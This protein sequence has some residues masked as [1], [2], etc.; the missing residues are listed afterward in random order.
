MDA[1]ASEA[2]QS[3]RRYVDWRDA[4]IAD[5][6]SALMSMAAREIQRVV[7]CGGSVARKAR[8][9]E[10]PDFRALLRRL[11]ALGA[12]CRRALGDERAGDAEAVA[13]YAVQQGPQLALG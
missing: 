1:P 2:E 8:L 7:G 4:V 3:L 10:V 13:R 11:P 6:R 5:C 12:Y 9:G